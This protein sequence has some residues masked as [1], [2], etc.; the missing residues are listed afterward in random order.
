[1]YLGIT[2]VT[3]NHEFHDSKVVVPAKTKVDPKYLTRDNNFNCLIFNECNTTDRFDAA[4]RHVYLQISPE[5][6]QVGMKE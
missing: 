3:E 5:E 1:M 2:V 4:T 6:H